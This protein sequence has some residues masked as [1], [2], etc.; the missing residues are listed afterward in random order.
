MTATSTQSP[1]AQ[2]VP[3]DGPDPLAAP[4][5]ADVTAHVDFAALSRAAT[6]AGAAVRPL[7]R[8]GEFLIRLGLVQRANVLGRDKDKKTRDMLAAD[9]ERLAGPKAMGDL[10]KV[11]ALSR[12]G[13]HLPVF[14]P[15]PE[16]QH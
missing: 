7:M 1:A 5:E 11:L 8:Q 12:P 9:M 13:L 14:D 16:S 4:G 6:E 15:L 2:P 10:F 3:R